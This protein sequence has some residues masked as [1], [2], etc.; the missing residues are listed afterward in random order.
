MKKALTTT[1]IDRAKN[2][3]FSLDIEN[4]YLSIKPKLVRES[5]LFFTRN[6]PEENKKDLDLFIK[7]I[8][9]GM[10]AILLQFGEEYFEYGEVWSW[11]GKVS[12]S[13]ATNQLG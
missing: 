8:G 2:T 12:Q 7:L 13:E 3:V 6:I 5:I 10:N 1:K 4:M 9:K 11:K